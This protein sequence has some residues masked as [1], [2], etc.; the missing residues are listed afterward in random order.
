M[1]M[2]KSLNIQSTDTTVSLNF[3]SS[4]TVVPDEVIVHVIQIKLHIG[5]TQL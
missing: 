3:V 5:N 1:Q 2:L 4:F